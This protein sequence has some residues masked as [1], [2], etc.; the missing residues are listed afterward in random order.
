MSETDPEWRKTSGVMHARPRKKFH[1]K[2]E[3][4]RTLWLPSPRSERS[5]NFN[6][7]LFTRTDREQWVGF[8]HSGPVK[9]TEKSF[10]WIRYHQYFPPY[11]TSFSLATNLEQACICRRNSVVSQNFVWILGSLSLPLPSV[12]LSPSLSGYGIHKNDDVDRIFP[13]DLVVR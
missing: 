13:R 8:L 7:I 11:G 3:H 10:C 4:R 9:I 6:G 5:P 2:V 12:C 1:H